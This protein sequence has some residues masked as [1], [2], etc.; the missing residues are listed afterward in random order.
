MRKAMTAALEHAGRCRR[1]LK[2]GVEHLLAAIARDPES[3]AAF[4]L[5]DSGIAPAVVVARLC[6][7][8]DGSP[9]PERAARFTSA[10]MHVLDVAV[11]EA[12]RRGERTSATEHFALSLTR[13]NG[14]APAAL[15][16]E[17]GFTHHRAE[18]ALRAWHR[19][20]MPK[21]A[22]LRSARSSPA[23]CCARSRPRSSRSA[24]TGRW[25]GTFTST[26][27]SATRAS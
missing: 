23:P 18:A 15:L 4:M 7:G 21:Q 24:T 13:V 1:R 6:E 14:T 2:A 9:R 27:A 19:R 16:R 3:A 11:A 5:E 20:G 17:L 8:A 26:K 25:A 22:R 12:D 10:A